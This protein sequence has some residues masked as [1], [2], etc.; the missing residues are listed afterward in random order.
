MS[1]IYNIYI[2]IYIYF[3]IYFVHPLQD[4]FIKPRTELRESRTTDRTMYAV[5]DRGRASGY[6]P[7]S[8]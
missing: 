7:E 2:Y 1:T 3:E 6:D 5:V 4:A 8:L